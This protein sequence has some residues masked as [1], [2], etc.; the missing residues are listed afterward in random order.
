MFEKSGGSTTF[1]IYGIAVLVFCVIHV[2]L[3]KLLQRYS[4]VNG[5]DRSESHATQAESADVNNAI[6]KSDLL[7][8]GN[9]NV[10]VKGN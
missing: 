5:K 9:I 7:L 4:H 6:T 1:Q 8:T 3:Q 2:I 10:D